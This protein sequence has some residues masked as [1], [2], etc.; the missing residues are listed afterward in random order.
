VGKLS[1]GINM[2]ITMYIHYITRGSVQISLL[3]EEGKG[4]GGLLIQFSGWNRPF[5]IIT[6]WE[7]GGTLSV[8][9]SIRE[10]KYTH[11]LLKL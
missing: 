10:A 1:K 2:M 8:R 3:H 4:E 7:G 9:W 5:V 6:Y 11:K